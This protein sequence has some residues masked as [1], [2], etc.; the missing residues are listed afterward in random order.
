MYVRQQ[1]CLHR[2]SRQ[3]PSDRLL[4]LFFS[5]A[6]VLALI[7]PAAI[8]QASESSLIW[9]E[10]CNSAGVNLVQVDRNGDEPEEQCKRCPL[11]LIAGQKIHG[12]TASSPAI[13]CSAEFTAVSYMSDRVTN[14]A[15]AGQ[16]WPTCR[17][18]PVAE[19]ASHIAFLSAQSRTRMILTEPWR[20]PW[21]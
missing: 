15:K 4:P 3:R 20:A 5:F 9:V 21:S 14:D 10:V 12:I 13:L 17:G 6:L 7:F 2:M 8:T 18:P 19:S 11:C 1:V 16:F